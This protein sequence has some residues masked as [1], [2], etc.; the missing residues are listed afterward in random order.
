MSQR[1]VRARSD[2]DD[3]PT[4]RDA[5]QQAVVEL[6]DEA[7]AA[8]VAELIARCQHLARHIPE[9]QEQDLVIDIEPRFPFF[10]VTTERA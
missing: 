5:I 2:V 6:R 1:R 4:L 7:R 9:G 3:N 8:L 10:K